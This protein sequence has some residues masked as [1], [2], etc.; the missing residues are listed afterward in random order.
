[1]CVFGDGKHAMTSA[2]ANEQPPKTMSDDDDLTISADPAQSEPSAATVATHSMAS[3]VDPLDGTVAALR[4]T[5][6][7]ANDELH[8]PP[9][10]NDL[11][12]LDTACQTDD[13]IDNAL[14]RV[15]HAEQPSSFHDDELAHESEFAQT[16]MPPLVSQQTLPQEQQPMLEQS[17][18]MLNP[19]QQSLQPS[20]QLPMEQ[21]MEQPVEQTMQQQPMPQPTHNRRSRSEIQHSILPSELERESV[22]SRSM[23]SVAAWR[24]FAFCCLPKKK[25]A[26]NRAV[27][28][29]D[30]AQADVLDQVID[31]EMGSMHVSGETNMTVPPGQ[32]RHQKDGRRIRQT[33]DFVDRDKSGAI[34]FEEFKAGVYLMG[35]L[36]KQEQ[37]EA[38]E[39]DEMRQWFDGEPP[40]TPFTR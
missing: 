9:H 13:S 21:S 33:F 32:Q 12:D 5:A 25:A 22:E 6:A 31:G 14:A 17:M 29:M 36:D 10:G 20:M 24:R 16:S 26:R 4:A 11:A 15:P 3:T 7:S 40:V 1:M 30:V 34:D 38:V 23:E 37:L 18:P 27:L 8:D 28:P 39:E 19:L 35:F 2:P